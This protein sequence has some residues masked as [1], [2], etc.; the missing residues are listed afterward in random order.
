M[1]VLV[2]YPF[3]IKWR[4]RYCVMRHRNRREQ[5]CVPVNKVQYDRNVIRFTVEIF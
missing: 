5:E 1:T 2:A 3:M 4:D